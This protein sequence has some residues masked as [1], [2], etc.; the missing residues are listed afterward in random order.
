MK[1]KNNMVSSI[2]ETQSLYKELVDSNDD[3]NTGY[4]TSDEEE[5]E[6]IEKS[7]AIEVDDDQDEQ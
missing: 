6:D 1:G 2:N 4:L 5:E 3:W 7:G